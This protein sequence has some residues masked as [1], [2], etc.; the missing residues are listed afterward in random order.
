M[1]GDFVLRWSPRPVPQ[2]PPSSWPTST[3]GTGGIVVQLLLA[4]VAGAA[5]VLK[6]Y[7]QRVR[8]YW[9]AELAVTPRTVG[10]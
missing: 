10:W 9:G 6:L 7:W 5:Y 8:S 3:P 1:K 4:G 2:N